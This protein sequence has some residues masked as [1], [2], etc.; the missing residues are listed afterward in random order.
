L[1]RLS[2]VKALAV[3]EIT[4]QTA[5]LILKGV[6]N[7]PVLFALSNGNLFSRPR[8]RIFDTDVP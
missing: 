3:A 1:E 4:D 7:A 8:L 5:G 6:F 2:K